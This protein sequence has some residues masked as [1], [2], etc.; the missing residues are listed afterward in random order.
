MCARVRVCV[1]VCVRARAC[2][3]ASSGAYSYAHNAEAS[4]PLSTCSFETKFLPESGAFNFSPKKD[5]SKLQQVTFL[6]LT[7]LELRL[8]PGHLACDTRV[9]ATHRGAQVSE[10]MFC[11]QVPAEFR[12]CLQCVYEGQR[13]SFLRDKV[14]SN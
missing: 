2:A 9:S 11:V 1:C 7:S 8:Q 4:R 12:G 6:S 13:V 10:G 3:R 14:F 5:V